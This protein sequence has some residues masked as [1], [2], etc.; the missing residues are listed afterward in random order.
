[1]FE[2]LK[3]P[4]SECDII[5][6]WKFY[7]KTY[8]SVVCTTYNQ[9]DY[10]KDAIDSFLA[11]KTL[12]KFEIIIHDDA[13]SDNTV[14]IISNYKKKFPNIVRVILQS[15]NQYTQYAC[16]PW[17]NS[18]KVAKGE[19]VSFCEGDDFWLSERKIDND[20]AMLNKFSNQDLLFSNAI[21]L[22]KKNKLS[23]FL[24]NGE[25]IKIFNLKE[26]I[27]GGGA[28]MPTPTLTFRKESLGEFQWFEKAHIGDYYVQILTSIKGGAIYVPYITA[29]YRE[30][31]VGSW[32]ASN[33][34]LNIKKKKSDFVREKLVIRELKK[35]LPSHQK[36][37]SMILAKSYLTMS[38]NFYKKGITPKARLFALK[39]LKIKLL[40]LKQLSVL[41][42]GGLL[43]GFKR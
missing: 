16:K 38:I 17:F 8:L 5:K 41:F 26:V 20:I 42:F 27:E 12:F 13:S 33:K 34:S 39:S 1:M 40:G 24:N 36:S 23:L 35:L 4:A 32:S 14:S 10:L 25:K 9:E 2:K 37:F 43:F 29:A 21:R 30:D 19:L 15:D 18:L 3:A 22:I 28:F 11:Q 31:S 6:H 7:D